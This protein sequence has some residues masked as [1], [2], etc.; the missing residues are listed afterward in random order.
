MVI[1]GWMNRLIDLSRRNNLLFYKPVA[2]G[3]LE[4]PFGQRMQEFLNN[5]QTATVGDLIASNEDK[6]S[7]IR[8][9]SRKGL[10]NFEEKGLLTLYLALGRC[11]WTADD[12]GRDPVAPIILV[13]VGL[14][15][16]GQ[17][18][19]AT[20]IDIAGEAEVNPVLLHIF[21]REL[22]L[23]VTAELL[24][25]L[26]SNDGDSERTEVNLQA[27]LDYLTTLGRKLPGFKAESFA[28][29]GNFSFQKLA[30]VRD[31]ENRRAELQANDVVAAIAGDNT[32][33]RKLGGS[34]IETDPKS[35]DTILPVQRHC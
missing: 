2:S 22:N 1:D 33:R 16:K 26:Y 35:L 5:G 6:I 14:K 32:A 24:L 31:L 29:L 19:Q 27:V 11:T 3:T 18:L 12:G 25:G 17:D 28:V 21:N 13:P 34:Q 4:L 7:A 15:F 9:I 10:E 23:P 30:M 8:A 20:E